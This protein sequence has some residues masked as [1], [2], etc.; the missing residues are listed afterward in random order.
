MNKLASIEVI[1]FIK[2][3]NIND[4]I[5]NKDIEVRKLRYKSS[6]IKYVL[7]GLIPLNF[8]NSLSKG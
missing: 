3:K 5:N 7:E 6:D 2:N 4:L 8:K 1:G